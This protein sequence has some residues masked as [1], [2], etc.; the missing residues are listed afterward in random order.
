MEIRRAVP[1]DEDALYNVALLTGDGGADG[2]GLFDD[3]RLLGEIFV[4]PYLHLE[5]DFAYSIDVEGIAGYLLGCLDTRTLESRC[6]E[7][8][9]P[10][11]R[12]RY[13]LDVP[14]RESDQELVQYIHAPEDRP[15]AL[16]DSYPSHLHIDLVPRAQGR[17]YG[18]QLLQHLLDRLAQA[19]SHGVHL[20]VAAENH[21]AQKVYRSLGFTDWQRSDSEL[22]MVRTLP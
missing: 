1:A 22:I 12:A 14:R 8:W 19:G 15:D 3:P 6:A 10:V 16:V 9:W 2:T 13:P 17:G 11:L 5:P 21:R 7:T 20:G 18:P 4:G